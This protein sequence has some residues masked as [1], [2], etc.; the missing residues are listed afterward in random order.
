[1]DDKKTKYVLI[2]IK[3]DKK[4]Q[5]LVYRVID[6]VKNEVSKEEPLKISFEK[7]SYI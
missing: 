7:E 2:Y 5:N 6:L 4:Q 3:N 1:L